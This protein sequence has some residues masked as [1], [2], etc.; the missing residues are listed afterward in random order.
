MAG[1][2]A[3]E[4][5]AVADVYFCNLRSRSD[6]DNKISKIKKL[7]KK[8]GFDKMFS[9][10]MLVAVKL[11]FGE[12]GNDTFIKPMFVR[13]VVD[14]LREAGACPFLTDSNTLYKGSRHDAVSHLE[15]ALEHGFGYATVNAPLIIADGLR[16]SSFSEVT[17]NKKHFKKVKI[18]SGIMEAGGMMVLSH[19]KGHEMAGFGGAIK[20]LAMGCAP[21]QGKREQHAARFYVQEELCIRCGRCMANCPKDAISWV[22]CGGSKAASINKDKCVGCGECLTVCAPKA[23]TIDWSSEMAPFNERMAEYAYGAVCGKPGRTG[24]VNFLMNITPDCDCVSWSDAPIVPDIGILA[25]TDPVA[26]D[27]ACL[28]L[29][30]KQK[31]L[32]GSILET[33]AEEGK[34]KFKHLWKHTMG[35]VQLAHAEAIGMGGRKYTLVEIS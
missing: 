1:S 14:K 12:R 9:K 28:D 2:K 32:P 22:K 23:V 16:G 11:H 25:S 29:V 13:A 30:N 34:D 21:S 27:Q 6:R 31:S 4:K 35:D 10:G 19:F 17:I 18:A 24:Y 26:L 20:N 5:S 33:D 15:T 7:F 3:K 8:A